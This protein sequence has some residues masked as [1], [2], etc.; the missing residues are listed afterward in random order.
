MIEQKNWM[1]EVWNTE[2]YQQLKRENF[3]L[4]DKYLPSAP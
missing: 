2:L 1:D 3:E 4:V